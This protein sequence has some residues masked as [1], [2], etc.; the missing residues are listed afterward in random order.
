MNCI[1]LRD[2]AKHSLEHTKQVK[3][4]HDVSHKVAKKTAQQWIDYDAS[5]M[6]FAALKRILDKEEPDYKN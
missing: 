4:L 1:T 5:D 3:K 2:H 6:H